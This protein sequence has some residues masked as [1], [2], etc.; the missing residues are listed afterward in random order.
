MTQVIKIDSEM[1]DRLFISTYG[2]RNYIE[3]RPITYGPD[4]GMYILGTSVANDPAYKE[5]SEEL[6]SKI[7]DVDLNTIDDPKIT[8]FYDPFEEIR[9][10]IDQAV[11][12]EVS[13]EN[14]REVKLD[15]LSLKNEQYI[16]KNK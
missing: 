5:F 3:P 11:L 7:A 9:N 10:Q 16:T 1:A 2:S 8:D 14:I 12:N 15:Q 4:K 6:L 13:L